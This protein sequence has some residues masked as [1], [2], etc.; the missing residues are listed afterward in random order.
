MKKIYVLYGENYIAIKDY[1]NEIANEY[2][3]EEKDEFSYV[4][5]NMQENTIENLVYE[6]RSSG[7]FTTKK[8]VVAVNCSFLL[9]KPKKI[10]VEHNI[11]VLSE[12]VKNINDDVILILQSDE[13][14]DSRKK[15]I[16][17]IKKI[18]EIKEFSNFNDREIVSYIKKWLSNKKIT[19]TSENCQFLINYS[20]LD[21]LN[22]K[23]ELEK[24]YLYCEEK[25]EVAKED[26]E[27]LVTRSIEY[28]VFSLTNELF[29]KNLFKLREVLNSLIL[30]K[31][32][33]IY[34]L[35]L[36]AS[37]LRVYYKVKV[38]LMEHY[39]QKDI[40]SKLKIHPYRVQ[41]WIK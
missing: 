23:K 9:A 5:L 4:K 24:L 36:I 18:G 2:L 1:E 28:D 16:K 3:K 17:D 11:E 34:L 20:G 39:N 12:Y 31:E 27:L 29:N 41:F 13:K 40:A 7:F 38:L 8:V 26:I 37:Q 15:I 14:I 30:K 22:I 32:E 21:F 25:G 35:S 33:P 6:C 19:I 10:K